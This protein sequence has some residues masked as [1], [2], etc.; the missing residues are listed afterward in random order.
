VHVQGRIQDDTGGLLSWIWITAI[1]LDT[2]PGRC[3]A[4]SSQSGRKWANRRSSRSTSERFPSRGG[5][6]E[7]SRATVSRAR[8]GT[9]AFGMGPRGAKLY[10]QQRSIREA[11]VLRLSYR[12]R[13]V[14]AT[15]A[16]HVAAVLFKRLKGILIFSHRTIGRKLTAV[17]FVKRG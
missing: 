3:G 7:R 5:G 9:W 13:V 4:T 12:R 14:W 11:V 8:H 2:S 10:T 16:R 15:F 6:R 17:A 1:S